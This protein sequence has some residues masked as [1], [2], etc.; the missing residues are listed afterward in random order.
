MVVPKPVA[1]G[2]GEAVGVTVGVGGS[3]AAT[4][5]LIPKGSDGATVVVGVADRVAA[6]VRDADGEVVPDLVG[7]GVA[8]SNARPEL[9]QAARLVLGKSNDEQAVAE[10]L[11]ELVA[12]SRAATR[13]S[14]ETECDGNGAGAGGGKGDEGGA[15][16]KN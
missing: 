15:P 4:D 12:Y 11:S 2:D 1:V 16:S 9:K 3:E 7:L 8:V 6:P 13:G 14:T 5:G 10:C